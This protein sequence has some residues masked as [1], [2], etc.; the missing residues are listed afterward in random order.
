[1]PVYRSHS[2]REV[3][4]D[5]ISLGSPVARATRIARMAT[6]RAAAGIAR[7]PTRAGGEFVRN[8]HRRAN[9][10]GTRNVAF[11]PDEIRMRDYPVSD[12]DTKIIGRIASTS[13]RD[14]DEVP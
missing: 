2:P 14:E 1:M 8:R 6:P 9:R 7:E 12:I 11:E 10:A 13:F 3:A 5:L 4:R